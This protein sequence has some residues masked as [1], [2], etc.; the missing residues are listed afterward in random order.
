MGDCATPG[1]HPK[2]TTPGIF[3][4][5]VFQVAADTSPKLVSA[6]NDIVGLLNAV[7]GSLLNSLAQTAINAAGQAV[8]EGLNGGISSVSQSSIQG[9]G[10]TSSIPIIPLTCAPK[11]QIVA[12]GTPAIIGASGGTLDANANPPTYTWYW[13]TQIG[14][15]NN[16]SIGPIFSA[17]FPSAA[18]YNVVL[19]DSANDTS[20]ICQVTAQ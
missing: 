20:T 16:N 17:S 3:T 5:Y 4:G 8:N 12:V 13:T 6:A 9:G 14:G 7:L 2:V 1:M 15:A 19:T 18:T 10:S 11:T